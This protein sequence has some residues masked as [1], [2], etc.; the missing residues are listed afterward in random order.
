MPLHALHSPVCNP[1]RPGAFRI[2][3]F[4]PQ[5]RNTVRAQA[6]VTPPPPGFDFRKNCRGSWDYMKQHHRELTDLAEEGELFRMRIMRA[7]H[8][9]LLLTILPDPT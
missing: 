9:V 1:H 7:V 3:P 6:S 2:P 5:R 8:S 4:Q